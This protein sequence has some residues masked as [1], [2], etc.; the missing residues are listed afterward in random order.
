MQDG[1]AAFRFHPRADRAQQR[2]LEA[3]TA[4]GKEWQF[5]YP[6]A[7]KSARVSRRRSKKSGISSGNRSVSFNAGFGKERVGRR[8]S[9]S[10]RSLLLNGKEIARKSS[11][12]SKLQKAPSKLLTPTQ[13]KNHV[14]KATLGSQSIKKK[15]SKTMRKNLA[16]SL[17]SWETVPESEVNDLYAWSTALDI[18]QDLEKLLWVKTSPS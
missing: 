3:H 10:S 14:N 1:S 13:Y 17:T 4:R 15:S 8:A 11:G 7:T 5:T 12:T 9:S 18:D 6:K 16:H 2:K